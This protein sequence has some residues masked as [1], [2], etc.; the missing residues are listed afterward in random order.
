MPAEETRRLSQLTKT[1]CVNYTQE[2]GPLPV[3]SYS[4]RCEGE[5]FHVYTN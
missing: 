4:A 2:Y 5:Q 1:K 3:I